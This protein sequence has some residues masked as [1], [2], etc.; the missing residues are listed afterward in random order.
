MKDNGNFP[1]LAN[2]TGKFASLMTS[3]QTLLLKENILDCKFFFKWIKEDSYKVLKYCIFR[4]CTVILGI[5]FV[6]LSVLITNLKSNLV[7]RNSCL[8]NLSG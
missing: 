2:Q 6:E 1:F 7:L 4:K 5:M 8:Q 3:R